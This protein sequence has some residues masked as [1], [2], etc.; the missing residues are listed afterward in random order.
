[1][2]IKIRSKFNSLLNRHPIPDPRPHFLLRRNSKELNSLA[3]L[4]FHRLTNFS[5]AAAQPR[6]RSGAAAVYRFE[7]NLLNNLIPLSFPPCVQSRENLSF[8]TFTTKTPPTIGCF[9]SDI[10]IANK[11]FLDPLPS[12]RSTTSCHPVVQD[13]GQI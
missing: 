2:S 4:C 8:R 6:A 1:M 9:Y 11:W 10:I 12:I 13:P 7:R 5:M 3:Q